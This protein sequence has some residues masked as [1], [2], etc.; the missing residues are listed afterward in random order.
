M[1][2]ASKIMNGN[3]ESMTSLF[4]HEKLQGW[5]MVL[6]IILFLNG[7]KKLLLKLEPNNFLIKRDVYCRIHWPKSNFKEHT[8][9]INF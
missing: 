8:H 3:S 4:C 5:G 7:D 6:T 1:K 9:C 2:D